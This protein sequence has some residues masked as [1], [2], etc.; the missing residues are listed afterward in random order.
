M[1]QYYGEKIA[2]YFQFVSYETSNIFFMSICGFLCQFIQ[3]LTSDVS[4]I[5]VFSGIAYGFII[6]VWQSYNEYGWKKT[7]KLFGLIYG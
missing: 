2:L 3:L 4:Q 7:E 6:A 5:Y 1:I